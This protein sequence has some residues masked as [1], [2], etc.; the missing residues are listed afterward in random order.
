MKKQMD[1]GAIKFASNVVFFDENTQCCVYCQTAEMQNCPMQNV[2]GVSRLIKPSRSSVKLN[3]L[4]S[5][6]V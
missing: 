4:Y 1:T 6:A 3:H 2:F 5:N